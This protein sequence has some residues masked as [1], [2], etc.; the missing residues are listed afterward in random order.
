MFKRFLKVLFV[1]A[2]I[3]FVLSILLTVGALVTSQ[4]MDG[5]FVLIIGFTYFVILILQITQYV[6]YGQFSPFALF[7]SERK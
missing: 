4:P 5:G 3:P 1:V 2:F 7:I 6:V